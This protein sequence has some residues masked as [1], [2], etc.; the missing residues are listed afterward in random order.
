MT[1][2]ISQP[3]ASYIGSVD[4]GFLSSEDIKALSVKRIQNPTTFDSL[5]HPVPGGLYDTA[6]GAWSDNLLVPSL[7][8]LSNT[9]SFPKMRNMSIKYL[10][11]PGPCRS[12]R[13]TGSSLSC[14][15]HGSTATINEI[16]MCLLQPP[17]A[18]AC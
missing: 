15:F 18:C 14:Y 4:F 5:L 16:E 2:N 11:L 17:K 7:G 1:M 3:I 9:D 10:L 13:A 12:Y 6:L 8:P